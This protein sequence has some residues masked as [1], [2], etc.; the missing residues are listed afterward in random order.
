MAGW[1]GVGA[2]HISLNTMGAG[3]T[4][5]DDHLNAIRRFAAEVLP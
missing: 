2:T 3:L 4:T 5:P 1:H